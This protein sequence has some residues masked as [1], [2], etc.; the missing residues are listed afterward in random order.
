MKPNF[1][2]ILAVAAVLA[3]CN[4]KSNLD[5]IA[6]SSDTSQTTAKQDF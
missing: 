5:N 6:G 1:I 4:N 2:F 3:A